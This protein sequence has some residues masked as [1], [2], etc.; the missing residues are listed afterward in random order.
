M[1]NVGV[2]GVGYWGPNLIRNF[3]KNP[4]TH[5]NVICDLRTERLDSLRQIYPSLKAVQDY[6]EVVHSKDIDLVV[7][8]TPVSTHYPL[9][10]DALLEGKDI[11]LTKPMTLTSTEAEELINL[12]EQ[13]KRHIFVDHTF[14]FTGAVNKIKEL[15]HNGQIGD[16][17]YFDSVRVNLGLF[18]HDV[19]VIWDLAPH[20]I[21]IMHNLLNEYPESIVAT[22]AGHLGNKLEDVAYLTAYFKNN[23][24]AHIH[25]NWLSP[26]KIRKTIIGGSEK[27]LVWDDLDSAEKI[28]IYDKGIEIQNV[29]RE[30]RHRLL[31]SYRFGDMY[32]PRIDHT[33]ALSLVVKE[34]ADC[35]MENRPAITDGEAGLRILRI[36]EAAEQS[37]K[38]EGANVPIGYLKEI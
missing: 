3:I 8:A 18:Q 1:I 11:L 30:D 20:D 24:I 33:E 21:S 37:I 25:V 14:L 28:K 16:L 9:A 2:I 36:L 13:K 5:V 27:M 29:D 23:L 32:A 31:V 6:R 35:I 22:G 17:F 19:N 7:I 12:S 4:H 38:T 15:I 26:V 34:F 10:K